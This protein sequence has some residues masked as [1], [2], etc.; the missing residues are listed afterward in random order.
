MSEVK[1]ADPVK[2]EAPAVVPTTKRVQELNPSRM[3]ECEF[4]RTVY[5][6]TTHENTSPEDL[7]KPEYWTNV[8][9]KFKPFDKV[10]ARAD[11]GSWYAELLVLETSRRWTRMHML[12][13]HNLTT[14]DVSLT[15]SKLQEFAVEFKG[16]HRKHC[17]IRISDQEIIHE[18][19]STKAGAHL[20]LA[21][22]IKAG[23]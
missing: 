22:R 17:V 4:E 21:E 20:W 7:L 9:E 15:Q 19:E 3:K 10:E 18:G 5:T 6:C 13:A 14:Q 16:P 1:S 12:A 2:A 8:A 23:I 11:D